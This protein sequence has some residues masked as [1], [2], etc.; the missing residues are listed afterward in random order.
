MIDVL[1]S[2]LL[3]FVKCFLLRMYLIEFS[4]CMS[5]CLFLLRT[6]LS[7]PPFPVFV[8]FNWWKHVLLIK[9]RLNGQLM[10]LFAGWID[11]PGMCGNHASRPFPWQYSQELFY[12]EVWTP[13]ILSFPLC[14]L[15]RTGKKVWCLVQKVSKETEWIHCWFCR[16]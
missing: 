2:K 6:K 12:K 13:L 3:V 8:T 16:L 15:W 11:E 9:A 5:L 1:L 14:C 4:M 10:I 7:H